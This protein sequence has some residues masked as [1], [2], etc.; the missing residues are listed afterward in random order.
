MSFVCGTM[1]KALDRS[2]DMVTVLCGGL[3]WLKPKATLCVRGR[4][5]EV[6]QWL[7]L[8]PCWVGER[9]RVRSSGRRRRSKTLAEGH[10]R[11]MGRYPDPKLAGLPGFRIGITM[12]FFQME[13][14]S[15]L[16]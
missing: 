10:S 4:R 16:L 6:V 11:D 7:S 9:G 12:E 5:A 14:I 8:K 2:I 1:S 15:A 3:G 13:G